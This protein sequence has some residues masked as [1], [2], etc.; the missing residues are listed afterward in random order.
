MQGTK[1]LILEKLIAKQETILALEKEIA[2]KKISELFRLNNK[3]KIF[4]YHEKKELKA[5]KRKMKFDNPNRK[6]EIMTYFS[7]KKDDFL[8]YLQLQKRKQEKIFYNKVACVN[9]FTIIYEV[10]ID[11]VLENTKLKSLFYQKFDN[12]Q[13][14][15]KYF[16]DLKQK[17]ISYSIDNIFRE[18]DNEWQEKTAQLLLERGF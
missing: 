1:K 13:Q 10:Y 14:A 7:S 6:K 18:I 9:T 3:K 17:I 12:Y 16:R 2:T 5:K 15:E 11:I 8:I 4:Y